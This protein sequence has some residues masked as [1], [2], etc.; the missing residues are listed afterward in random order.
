MKNIKDIYIGI[1]IKF[2]FYYLSFDP[3][4]QN[5]NYV[6]LNS[7]FMVSFIDL[8]SCTVAFATHFCIYY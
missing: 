6:R 2:I 7:S 4:S 8:Y 5:I 1:N 3:F